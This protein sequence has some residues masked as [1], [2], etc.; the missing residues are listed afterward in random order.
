MLQHLDTLQHYTSVTN[1]SLRNAATP[2]T[3]RGHVPNPFID[4]SLMPASDARDPP[5]RFFPGCLEVPNTIRSTSPYRNVSDV[6]VP[7]LGPRPRPPS[8]RLLK[9]IGTPP[10][11]LSQNQNS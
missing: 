6:A 10:P 7:D 11:P 4:Q 1:S 3:P 8:S 2:L 5:P 9:P